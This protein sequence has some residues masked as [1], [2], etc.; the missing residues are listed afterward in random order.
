MKLFGK[1]ALLATCL[2]VIFGGVFDSASANAAETAEVLHWWTSGGESKAVKEFQKAFN[3]AGG[4]WVDAAIA[5]GDAARAAGINRIAGGNAPTAMQF[6]T[7]KEF[8]ELI[9]QGLLNNL[10]GVAAKDHWKDV[11][12]PL[13]LN[14][15]SRDGHIYGAPVDIHSTVWLWYSPDALKAVGGEPPKTW[16]DFFVDADK[17]KA[18][19]VLPL[20]Q[21]GDAWTQVVTFMNVLVGAGGKDLYMKV[22]KDND[23]TAVKSPEFHKVAEIFAKLRGYSD[24][25]QQGRQ[26]NQ[27]ISLVTSG[28]AGFSFMGDW[29]KGEI[30]AEGKKPGVDV[31]C[32]PGLTNRV[33]WVGGDV[34]VFPKQK[35]VTDPVAANLLAHVMLSP[36][37]QVAFNSIKGSVPVRGDVETAKL[38]SC[39][40]QGL[41]LLKSGDY[42]PGA[43][44]LMSA[45]KHGSLTDLITTFWSDKSKS[46]DDFVGQFSAFIAS[47]E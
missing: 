24:E 5:G 9:S 16:D 13:V 47:T 28:K 31:G 2:S 18:A 43:E 46:A 27:A 11:V 1:S 25:G 8:D 23:Q 39:A 10:D 36:E 4:E 42:V 44:Q 6:I 45:D 22:L 40:Q 32:V 29:A 12:N 41:A 34:F 26:W 19:G 38:D 7:S 35:G 30:A 33:Y 37:T 14:A 21:S 15:V 20:A 3:A 17:L